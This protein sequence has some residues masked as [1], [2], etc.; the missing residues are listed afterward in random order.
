MLEISLVPARKTYK[1]KIVPRYR[2]LE[3]LSLQANVGMA[4]IAIFHG[5]FWRKKR[6][7]IPLCC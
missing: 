1:G 4:L 5:S 6:L 3:F 2:K 7:L